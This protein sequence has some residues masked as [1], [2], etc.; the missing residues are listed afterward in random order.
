ME[1]V[2]CPS[3]GKLMRKSA[4]SEVQSNGKRVAIYACPN[5]A[6]CGAVVRKEE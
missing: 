5:S 6:G 1:K 3:C 2:V 4:L